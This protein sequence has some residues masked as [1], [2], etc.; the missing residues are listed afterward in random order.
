MKIDENQ[1]EIRKINVN[2]LQVVVWGFQDDQDQ[3]IRAPR[4]H[5]LMPPG[6]TTL[7]DGT[8]S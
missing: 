1:K 8:P 5:I 3:G 4:G 7:I 6:S 2:Q